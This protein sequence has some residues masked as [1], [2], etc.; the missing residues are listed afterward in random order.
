MAMLSSLTPPL[1]DQ[2]AVTPVFFPLRPGSPVTSM[3]PKVLS[4]FLFSSDSQH[5]HTALL[6]SGRPPGGSLPSADLPQSPRR[7]VLHLLSQA[8]RFPGFPRA[9]AWTPSALSRPVP[10][11]PAWC[12]LP[13]GPQ[14]P[15]GTCG[16]PSAHVLR[17]PGSYDCPLPS[18]RSH[19]LT[20]KTSPL[21]VIWPTFRKGLGVIGSLLF[22]HHLP[23]LP[24][25]SSPPSSFDP[26]HCSFPSTVSAG[27]VPAHSAALP[28]PVPRQHHLSPRPLHQASALPLLRLLKPFSAWQPGRRQPGR[29]LKMYRWSSKPPVLYPSTVLSAPTPSP[30]PASLFNLSLWYHLAARAPWLP[31]LPCY[32]SHAP[33]PRPSGPYWLRATPPLQGLLLPIP[34]VRPYTCSSERPFL[35]PPINLLTDHNWGS[36]VLLCII[37]SGRVWG[38]DTSELVLGISTGVSLRISG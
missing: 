34:Q 11:C 24:L 27:L 33:A 9:A 30:G 28:G 29:C 26:N 20:H 6:G 2:P 12:C 3:P 35:S 15:P 38:Q 32:P 10:S 22:P 21:T 19:F 7:P 18:R 37:I 17:A 13:R 16:P 8:P 5:P 4:L 14:T 23:L 25:Q 1:P 36:Y 31:W